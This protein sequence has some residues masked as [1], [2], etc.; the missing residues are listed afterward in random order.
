MNI[1]VIDSYS[2]VLIKRDIVY[3]LIG[4][5]LN[6]ISITNPEMNTNDQRQRLRYVLCCWKYEKEVGSEK[7]SHFK[8]GKTTTKLCLTYKIPICTTYNTTFHNERYLQLSVCM[9][10]Y[11][12]KNF[13]SKRESVDVLSKSKKKGV[14]I[15]IEN[16]RKGRVHNSENNNKLKLTPLRISHSNISD[17]V[18]LEQDVIKKN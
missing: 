7:I 14:C 1:A 2:T 12:S 15:S 16:E 6:H 9:N 10:K 4:Y 8:Q 18:Q 3:Q 17:A 13:F 5:K 11:T